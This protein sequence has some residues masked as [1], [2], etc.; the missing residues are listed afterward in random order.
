M[1]P[2]KLNK[3]ITLQSYQSIKDDEGIVSKQWVNLMTVYASVEP[4]SGREYWQAAATQSE[5]TVKFLIRYKQNITSDL[6][7]IYNNKSYDVKS[8]IDPNEAHKELILM[9]A[10]VQND[11]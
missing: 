10:E 2:G 8:V 1:N 5:N 6:R 9:C 7:L 4:L 3:R 11:N